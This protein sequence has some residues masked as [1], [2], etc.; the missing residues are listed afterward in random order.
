MAVNKTP[1]SKAQ[2]QR[3]QFIMIFFAFSFGMI[4][5]NLI[6][7]AQEQAPDVVSDAVMVY[8]GVDKFVEDL[9]EAISKEFIELSQSTQER[10]KQLLYNAALKWQLEDYAV[11]Q[12]LSLEEAGN[13]L[14]HLS[15]P[16][17]E[18]INAFYVSQADKINKPFYEVK[19]KI[20]QHLTRQQ[21][22]DA[23]HSKIAELIEK[24]DLA[25]L[26]D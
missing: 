19:E 14:F 2:A 6:G 26:I 3:S 9:P 4:L 8:R 24:G 12:Q 22:L 16:S 5:S 18:Q 21:A 13:K 11:K 17:D 7:Q 25:L 10:K 15:E 1:A 20:F 23:R